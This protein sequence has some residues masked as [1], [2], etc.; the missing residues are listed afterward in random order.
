MI[1]GTKAMADPGLA[2]LD[3]LSFDTPFATP[4]MP[5]ADITFYRANA[6]GA[7]REKTSVQQ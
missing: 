3:L 1:D 5:K 7:R 2:G 6:D 4:G